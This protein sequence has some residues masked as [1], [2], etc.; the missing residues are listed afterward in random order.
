MNNALYPSRVNSVI[1]PY[2]RH[3][4][5]PM[6][7]YQNAFKQ[8]V[9]NISGDAP[10]AYPGNEPKTRKERKIWRRNTKVFVEFHSLLFLQIN[11][12]LIPFDP[13]NYAVQMLP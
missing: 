5:A 1:P 8:E 6:R 3:E 7:H 10:P 13:T 2:A 9:N 11:K 12:R 4:A